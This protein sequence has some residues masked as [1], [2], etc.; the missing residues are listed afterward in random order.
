LASRLGR[1]LLVAL[2]ARLGLGSSRL[3]LRSADVD[4]EA[5]R[6]AVVEEPVDG[7]REMRRS[8]AE[9]T[10]GLHQHGPVRE[11]HGLV[12][13]TARRLRK[14]SD[15]VRPDGL[16][17]LCPAIDFLNIYTWRKV[18]R[19]HR[20]RLL[21]EPCCGFEDLLFPFDEHAFWRHVR[22][23]LGTHLELV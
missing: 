1:F 6:A 11:E 5:P 17:G 3:A 22:G 9:V 7:V 14:E 8:L 19:S 13:P 21:L 10:E 4:H 12:H 15:G 16:D 2:L 23:S 20:R 18:A